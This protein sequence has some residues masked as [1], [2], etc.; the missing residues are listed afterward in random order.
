MKMIRTR[1][2]GRRRS[3][4]KQLSNNDDSSVVA[5]NEIVT[6][7]GGRENPTC[8]QL[9][10]RGVDLI[11]FAGFQNVGIKK[12]TTAAIA[13]SK[14]ARYWMRRGY[15]G[16]KPMRKGGTLASCQSIGKHGYI[17]SGVKH[18]LRR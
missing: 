6:S 16:C 9:C 5:L 1:R 14:D 15:K 7:Y 4:R 10:A 2:R 13:M 18:I 11:R 3:L 8:E 17:K 12:G